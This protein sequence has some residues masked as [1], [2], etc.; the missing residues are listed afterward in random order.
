MIFEIAP[1]VHHGRDGHRHMA[2]FTFKFDESYNASTLV[3]TGWIAE[4]THWKTLHRRWRRVIADVNRELP[5]DQKITRYHASHMNS[6]DGE[7]KGWDNR[8]EMKLWFTK[9]LFKTVS[10]DRMVAVASGIDL[11]AFCDLFPNRNPTDYGVAYTMCMQ[12]AMWRMGEALDKH[13]PSD[14]VTIIHDRGNWDV[15]A[16]QA[17]KILVDDPEWEYRNRFVAI[18]P[19]RWRDDT[20]LQSADL[21]GYE[22]MRVIDN[23]LWTGGKMRKAMEALLKCNPRICPAY[24]DRQA[25]EAVKKELDKGP[26]RDAA[27]VSGLMRE[28]RVTG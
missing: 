5:R 16:L 13:P 25:L 14:R 22:C 18:T 1:I 15:H 26:S 12:L 28:R 3:V 11:K 19:L 21:I 4:E 20:G 7:F 2:I 9:R 8:K 10:T 23:E 27:A 17:F 6:N 24:I